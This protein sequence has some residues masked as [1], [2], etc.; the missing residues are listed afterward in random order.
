IQ[1]SVPFGQ[2]P[3]FGGEQTIF[4]PG[5][6]GFNVKFAIEDSYK[7][8]GGFPSFPGMVVD[9]V[10]TRG[11]GVSYGL[12]IPRS[13]DNFVNAYP[14]GYAGQ[15]ITPYSMVLPFTYAG[16]TGGYMYRAPPVLQPNEER[17]YESYF[18][19][20]DGDVASIYD[21][22]LELRQLPTGTFGGHVVD[23]R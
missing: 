19:V 2:L 3:L 23:A 20:G 13:P 14:A 8:A 5:V 18:I 17:T 15:D 9:F 12:A 21:T 4:T 7:T 1:L 11:D 6:A 22:I 10:A 16:V